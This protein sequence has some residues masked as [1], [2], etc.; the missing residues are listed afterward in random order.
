[1]DLL[2]LSIEVPGAI[3]KTGY[4][5]LRALVQRACL[6]QGLADPAF[7]AAQ[8]RYLLQRVSIALQASNASMI[9]ASSQPRAL[10]PAERLDVSTDDDLPD[11]VVSDE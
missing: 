5:F 6:R 8:F 7:V 10:T 9:L 3:S 1:M 4:A 2:P 11:P